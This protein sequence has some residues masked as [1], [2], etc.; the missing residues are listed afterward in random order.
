VFRPGQN[1]LITDLPKP[2]LTLIAAAPDLLAACRAIEAEQRNYAEKVEEDFPGN[3]HYSER[4]MAVVR[5]AR[6]AIAKATGTEAPR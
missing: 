3:G 5:M 2:D 4:F 6:A 1:L